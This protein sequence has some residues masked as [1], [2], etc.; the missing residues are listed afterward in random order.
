MMNERT[1]PPCPQCGDSLQ[2]IYRN[3][4]AFGWVREYA[5][6][7]DEGLQMDGS[8]ENL[9]YTHPKTVRCS[10]CGKARPD[11]VWD[12]IVRRGLAVEGPDAS[13]KPQ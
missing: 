7:T 4:Q 3:V 13:D 9:Q 8:E 12:E 6:L 5:Y 2:G 1:I 10:A 11:I